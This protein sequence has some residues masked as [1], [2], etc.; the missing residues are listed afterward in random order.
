MREP[1]KGQRRHPEHIFSFLA[2][3]N[4]RE[5]SYQS[6]SVHLRVRDSPCSNALFSFWLKC[7]HVLGWS[8]MVAGGSSVI[9]PVGFKWKPV[10]L[11]LFLLLLIHGAFP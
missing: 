5:L 10:T 8:V 2:A 4:V 1:E 6:V 9:D 7:S 11:T 3:F